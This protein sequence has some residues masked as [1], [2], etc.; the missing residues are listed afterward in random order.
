MKTRLLRLV[1]GSLLL[2]L[3]AQAHFV[4]LERGPQG[5]AAFFGEYAENVRETESGYLKGIV[6]VTA[7]DEKGQAVSV[8][9]ETGALRLADAPAGDLRLTAHFRPEKGETLVRYSARLGVAQPSAAL[10]LELVPVAGERGAFAVLFKGAPQPEAEVTLFSEEG[11]SRKFKADGA[12]RVA[13]LTPWP[14]Q[15]V[16]ETAHTEDAAGV[17]EGRSHQKVRHVATLT[18]VLAR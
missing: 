16:L 12:G 9:R 1:L 5:V 14:G 15:Y 18:F 3:T 8:V 10:D 13:V 11:W 4:W 7:V 6:Q 17:F 2:A